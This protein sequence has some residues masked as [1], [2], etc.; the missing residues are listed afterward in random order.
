MN[1]P[2]EIKEHVD[3]GALTVGH[4]RALLALNVPGQQLEMARRI[5]EQGLSVR[6][7]ETLVSQ[8][9]VIEGPSVESSAPRRAYADT[10]DGCVPEGG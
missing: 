10:K 6:A 2:E 7:T 5:M 3:S 9:N 8:S 4:A 1:L